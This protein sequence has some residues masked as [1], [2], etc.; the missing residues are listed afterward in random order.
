MLPRLHP[1]LVP[2]INRLKS[3]DLVFPPLPL[4]FLAPPLELPL[5]QLVLLGVAAALG[6]APGHGP[7]NV[8]PDVVI[9]LQLL[10]NG[11]VDSVQDLLRVRVQ[12]HLKVVEAEVRTIVSVLVDHLKGQQDLL[13]LLKPVRIKDTPLQN[14]F[15]DFSS[16]FF[17]SQFIIF[18]VHLF[19]ELLLLFIVI[20]IKSSSGEQGPNGQDLAKQLG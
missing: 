13:Y 4:L 17:R 1:L 20:R 12:E 15:K 14:L 6:A 3:P 10:R 19:L 18:I 16:D 5:P 8:E 9:A 2:F 7:V 11:L